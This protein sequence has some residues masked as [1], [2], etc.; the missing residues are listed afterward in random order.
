M[1]RTLAKPAV[2]GKAMLT[3]PASRTGT[4]ADRQGK[5]PGLSTFCHFFAPFCPLWPGLVNSSSL[6]HP[7]ACASTE[8]RAICR[9]HAV[10]NPRLLGVSV[11]I[12]GFGGSGNR[13]AC[14]GPDPCQRCVLLD[15]GGQCVRPRRR[16]AGGSG[17]RAQAGRSVPGAHRGAGPAGPHPAPGAGDQPRRASDRRAARPRAENEGSAWSAARHPDPDQGQHR[18]RR[19]DDHHRRLPGA[20]RLAT[21]A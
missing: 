18:H 8:D 5:R 1:R 13:F 17:D 3:K 10:S 14:G 11:F 19:P 2:S 7:P 21:G 9:F 20:G 12:D 4:C 15:R 16:H 6:G